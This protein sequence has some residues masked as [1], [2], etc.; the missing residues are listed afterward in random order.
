MYRWYADADK[1]FVYLS[2]VGA[3][4]NLAADGSEFRKSRWFTR[5]WTLQELLAPSHLVFYDK[6]WGAIR[7]DT[8]LPQIVSEVTNIQKCYIKCFSQ[9]ENAQMIRNAPTIRNASMA[10]CMSW[11][12]NRTTSRKEDMAYCLLGLL[13]VTMPL[14]YGEG[15][16]AF[17]RLQEEIMRSTYDHTILAWGLGL[18]YDNTETLQPVCLAPSPVAFAAWDHEIKHYTR[19]DHY[20]QTNLGIR[21]DLPIIRLPR[22]N[23]NDNLGLAILDCGI[24]KKGTVVLPLEMEFLDPRVKTTL[25]ATR[26]RG[27]MPFLLPPSTQYEDLRRDRTSLYILNSTNPIDLPRRNSYERLYFMKVDL[28]FDIGY[29]VNDTFP[30]FAFSNV[31]DTLSFWDQC[32]CPRLIRLCHAFFPTVLIMVM[33]EVPEQWSEI[34]TAFTD[35]PK[36]SW[37]HVLQRD[38]KQI[39]FEHLHTSLSWTTRGH[40]TSLPDPT[41]AKG[42]ISFTMAEIQDLKLPSLSSRHS[43]WQV[44]ST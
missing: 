2:D 26:A 38:Y 13:G 36:T 41:F 33:P 40:I 28:L 12:S 44:Q 31:A 8:R 11:A 19:G 16:R 32:F 21:I 15:E 6:T 4:A 25:K 18:P 7:D 30:P 17:T 14:L 42:E 3:G 5:G 23:R 24:K 29:T 43:T 20:L 22:V 35:D 9:R 1:C 34:R 10:L 39:N 37:Q 27:I